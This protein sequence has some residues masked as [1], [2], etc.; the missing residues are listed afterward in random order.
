MTRKL[1]QN[2][3]EKVRFLG[4]PGVLAPNETP[5][6]RETHMSWVFLTKGLVFKLKKPVRYS[7][8]DFSTSSAREVACRE[9]FRINQRLAPG[10]YLRLA[11]LTREPDGALCV[12]GSGET[13]DW[14]VVMRRLPVEFMLDSR[15]RSG[16]AT[17]A[18]IARL[19]EHL[20]GFY[21][22]ALQDSLT[23]GDYVERF[24]RQLTEDR[25]TISLPGFAIDHGRAHAIMDRLDGRLSELDDVIR[26]RVSGGRIIEGHG[27]LRPEHV[28][29][30]DPILVIDRIEF[31]RDLRMV[32]PF[33]EL[34]FLGMECAV[35]G[36]HWVAPILIG[37]ASDALGAPPAGLIDFYT[38]ARA[39]LRA[40]LSLAHLLDPEPREPAK[41]APQAERYLD[42]AA[43]A[44]NLP[45][46]QAP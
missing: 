21:R 15:L 3:D 29:L 43:G 22:T 4:S 17:P 40:R 11:R 42:Q 33:D 6:T 38:A 35:A 7:Y 25:K 36:A 28:W 13:A 45:P 8:L 24:R 1:N 31:N 44:L 26:Q 39:S 30:G 37:A 23:P 16:A 41:W 19:T 20:L 10:V 9:E 32:D 27:D 5:Q 34:A 2:L 14:L 46:R 18:S 12:D